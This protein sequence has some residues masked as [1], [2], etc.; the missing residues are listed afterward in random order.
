MKRLFTLI[1]LLVVI[2]I[3]AILASMLLPALSQARKTANAIGCG[4]N[5]KQIGLAIHSYVSDHGEAPDGSNTSA[6]LYNTWDN[7][8]I[9]GYLGVPED[10]PVGFAPAVSKCLSPRSGINGTDD[11]GYTMPNPT[12]PNFSFAN[13]TYIVTNGDPTSAGRQHRLLFSK[14]KNPSTRLMS[15]ETGYDGWHRPYPDPPS[16]TSGATCLYARGYFAFRHQR[17]TNVVLVDGHLKRM[18]YDDIPENSNNTFI[19]VP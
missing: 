15:G 17:R 8:G 12:R 3:I 14:I 4:N 6:F 9:A 16:C 18:D 5:L 10:N 11:P 19:R 2:A 1:E 7:G 13:N